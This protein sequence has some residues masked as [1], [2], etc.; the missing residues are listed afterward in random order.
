GLRLSVI[1]REGITQMDAR[2]LEV[3]QSGAL[4]FRLLQDDWDLRLGIES[5]DP[6][7]TALTLQEVTFREGRTQTRVSARVRVENAAVRTLR[8][9]L[10]IESVHAAETVRITGPAVADA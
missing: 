4:A 3:R 8:V 10:P 6:W 5:M 1:E 7:V 9:S 2:E